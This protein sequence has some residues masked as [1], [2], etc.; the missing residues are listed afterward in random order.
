MEG[1]KLN[2][3][4]IL[5]AVIE[6]GCYAIAAAGAIMLICEIV[7]SIAILVACL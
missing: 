1:A 7:Q 3:K 4:E 6:A 2:H 5:I